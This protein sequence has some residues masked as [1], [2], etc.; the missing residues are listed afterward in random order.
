[1]PSKGGTVTA[2]HTYAAKVSTNMAMSLQPPEFPSN[3]KTSRNSQSEQAKDP[4]TGQAG[5]AVSC[6]TGKGAAEKHQHRSAETQSCR[7]Q[8]FPLN[9]LSSFS[10]RLVISRLFTCTAFHSQLHVPGKGS[11]EVHAREGLGAEYNC[12]KVFSYHR[13]RSDLKHSCILVSRLSPPALGLLA[14]QWHRCPA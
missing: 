4:P 3:Q 8:E 1:M 12:E 9:R 14:L 5:T 11:P 6:S 13:Y 10:A 7:E 2:F